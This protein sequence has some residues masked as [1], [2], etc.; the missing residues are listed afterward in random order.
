[1]KTW[2]QNPEIY[3]KCHGLLFK[4]NFKLARAILAA[5]LNRGVAWTTVR[6]FIFDAII[7]Y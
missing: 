4:T 2:V 3:T 5:N 1:M 7:Y 6:I